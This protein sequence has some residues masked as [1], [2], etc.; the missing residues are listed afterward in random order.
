M[1]LKKY[2]QQIDE[3]AQTLEKPY[4]HPLSQFA[5]MSE[6]L[7]EVGRLLNHM[8]GDKPKKTTE[9]KQELPEELADILFAVICMANSHNID[10]DKAM[11]KVIEKTT[12]RDSER[13]AKKP[14]YITI[15]SRKKSTAK[16]SLPARDRYLSGRIQKVIDYAARDNATMMILSGRYGLIS[17]ATKIPYYDHLLQHEEI[18]SL[19]P[20]VVKTLS[21]LLPSEIVFYIPKNPDETWEP[22]IDLVQRAVDELNISFSQQ[23]LDTNYERIKHTATLK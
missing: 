18:S 5:R 15:C 9:A 12:I 19:L 1:S 10:L 20:K 7:G 6:E 17:P 11:K 23:H 8:Y 3:W 4:W 13:F 21:V 16:G 22:Y 2:Q 14:L